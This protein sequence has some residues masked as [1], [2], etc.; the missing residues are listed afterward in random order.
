M[1]DS[2]G[3]ALAA[4]TT[5][6]YTVSGKGDS[7]SSVSLTGSGTTDESGV[8]S[9]KLSDSGYDYT[10]YI[11]EDNQ[12]TITVSYYDSEGNLTMQGSKSITSA[13]YSGEDG[14]SDTL[15]LVN[16]YTITVTESGLG[17]EE[18]GTITYTTDSSS[19]GKAEKTSG[20]SNTV[21]NGW[22]GKIMVAAPSGYR[23]SAIT[24]Q[25]GADSAVDESIGDAE[26][27]HTITVSSGVTAALK[28]AVTYQKTYTVSTS[29]TSS[30]GSVSY[31]YTNSS[32]TAITITDG[33][34]SIVDSG[35][36]IT[37][38]VTPNSGYQIS[39]ITI[40][41]T[42]QEVSDVY[43]YTSEAYTVSTDTAIVVTFVQEYTVSIIYD[44]NG[45][46]ATNPAMTE[47]TNGG[48]VTLKTGSSLKVT[49]TPN[50]GYRVFSVKVQKDGEEAVEKIA[51]T[52]NDTKW[53]ETF[54]VESTYTITV[55]FAEN[56]YGVTVTASGSD[57]SGC[58]ASAGASSV[59]YNGETDITVK[60]ADGYYVKS[61]TVAETADGNDDSGE[62]EAF[63]YDLKNLTYTDGSNEA[64]FTVSGVK[65]D[66]TVTVE[67]A[68]N[69]AVS[70]EINSGEALRTY[71]EGDN[72]ETTVYVYAGTDSAAVTN[73]A[74][75]YGI[76]SINDKDNS[77]SSESIAA[78]ADNKEITSLYFGSTNDTDTWGV[79]ADTVTY[80]AKAS[81]NIRVAFDGADPTAMLSLS[82]SDTSAGYYSGKVTVSVAASDAASD[83]DTDYSGIAKITYYTSE[84][85]SVVTVCSSEDSQNAQGSVDESFAVDVTGLNRDV[86][87]YVTVYD[88]AGNDTTETVV[89]KTYAT[90]IAIT[91]DH[92]YNNDRLD[93]RYFTWRTATIIVTDKDGLFK[94]DKAVITVNGTEQTGIEWTSDTA[95]TS[96]TGTV[97]Y[98]ATVSFT[99]EAE[100]TWSFDYSNEAGADYTL[101]S[102]YTEEDDNVTITDDSN[103]TFA[104][105]V[106][107]TAPTG[108]VLMDYYATST[109]ESASTETFSGL[110][111][112][113]G[114]TFD[115]WIYSLEK[116]YVSASDTL[117]GYNESMTYYYKQELTTAATSD[118]ST[119]YSLDADT[120][121]ALWDNW[122]SGGKTDDTFTTTCYTVSSD[123]N[124]VIYARIVDKA[125]NVSWISSDGSIV[126]QTAPSATL[127]LS[128]TNSGGW[129]NSD[130]EVTIN[131]A[132]PDTYTD[133]N[134]NTTS[135]NVSSGIERIEYKV[136]KVDRKGTKSEVTS[137]GG[138]LYVKDETDASALTTNASTDAVTAWTTGFTI[139][140]RAVS[141]AASVIVE[142]TVY[143]NV[144]NSYVVE[145]DNLEVDATTPTITVTYDN[146]D[147]ENDKYFDAER[148]AT[149]VITERS[150]D[151]AEE[152]AVITITAT[153]AN[154]DAVALA[155]VI[156]IADADGKELDY[157]AVTGEDGIT[158]TITVTGWTVVEAESPDSDTEIITIIYSGDANYTFDISYTGD[159]DNS[160][161]G[162]IYKDANGRI[163]DDAAKVAGA[164]FTVDKNSPSGYVTIDSTVFSTLEDGSYLFMTEP[165]SSL[166]FDYYASAIT[167]AYA[168]ATDETSP[169]T[170]TYYKSNSTT[171]ITAVTDLEK[172]NFVS[173]YEWTGILNQTFVVYAKIEDY[174]GNVTYVSS[175]GAIVDNTAPEITI[176]PSDAND[177][178]W[179]NGDIN[180]TLTATDSDV[181][182][183]DNVDGDGKNTSSGINR[184]VYEVYTADR[185]G[186][187]SRVIAYSVTRE[188]SEPKED[189]SQTIN[190]ETGKVTEWVTGFT[191]STNEVNNAAKVI[192]RATVYDNVGNVSETAEEVLYVDTTA[193]EILVTYDLNE[194]DVMNDT[195]FKAARTATVQIT[196]RSDG[197]NY[198]NA[199][200]TITAEDV[201]E[202]AI[203]I[204]T[205]I[206]TITDADG[207]ELTY[208]V[209][210]ETGVI[211]VDGWTVNKEGN[212]KNP[213]ADTM[214]IKI[215]YTGDANYTFAIAYTDLAGNECASDSESN[216][217]E[218][219]SETVAAEEFTV[220]TDYP[221]GYITI[222]SET[223]TKA[224]LL[225][226]SYWYMPYSSYTYEY[227]IKNVTEASATVT[228]ATSPIAEI[229]YYK[230]NSTTV[231][232]DT[233]VLDGYYDDGLFVSESSWTESA[234]AS[235]LNQTFVVYARI[236]DYAGNVTYVSSDA[237][238]ADDTAPEVTIIP[239]A[240][241]SNGWYDGNIDIILTATDNDTVDAESV[242]GDGENT[243]SGINRIKYSV[244]TLGR[245]ETRTLVDDL[246]GTYK[247]SEPKTTDS[248]T[249]NSSTGLVTSW[250]TGITIDAGLVNDAVAVIVVA[251]V[252]DNAGNSYE[253]E[254]S[255]LL[256]IKDP[257]I[258]VTYDDNSPEN[259]KYFASDRT[260]TV[261]ITDRA[262]GFDYSNAKITVTATDA[263]GNSLDITTDILKIT[264]ASGGELTYNVSGNTIT[265]DGWTV[266]KGS[267]P[268]SDTQTIKIVYTGDANYTF[269]IS[270]TDLAGNSCS[271]ATFANG[272]KAASAFTV[273]Q[274]APTGSITIDSDNTWLSSLLSKIT[275][276]IIS[277]SK[278]TVELAADDVTSPIILEYYVQEQT[279]DTLDGTAMTESKLAALDDSEWTT[280]TNANDASELSKT[281]SYTDEQIVVY[282]RITDYA[283]NVTY[284]GSNGAI[285]DTYSPTITLTP[286]TPDVD[287]ATSGVYGYYNRSNDGTVS[288]AV[289]VSDVDADNNYSALE[290]VTYQVLCNG[291]ETQSGTLLSFT[292]SDP[293]YKQ[294][295]NNSTYSGTIDVSASKNNS[296]DVVVKVTAVDKAGNKTTKSVKLDIDVTAP[297][298]SISYDNN[299]AENS[300]YFDATRTATIVITERT[301]HFDSD[302]V[303]ITITAVDA[304]GNTV[305]GATVSKMLS[306]WKTVEGSD[307]NSA[308]HTAT[309]TYSKDANYTF[310]ISYTDT[311]GNTA[312]SASTGD[313]VAPYKFTVDT[314][315]PTGT[316]TYTSAEGSTNT[317]SS[318]IKKLT[319][320]FYSN[321]KITVS[322]TSDDVTSPIASVKY[323]KTSGT[324]ALT[325]S[326]LD[327]LGSSSWK[328]FSGFS[329]TSDEQF[330]V[331][332]K[333][334]DNAGNYTYIST[335]G[336][337]VDETRP[338]EETLAPE[339]TLTQP[340]N[341][342]YSGDVTVDVTVA[343]PTSGGTYSGLKS[344]TYEVY[345]LGE[346]TQSGTLYTFTNDSPTQSQ[347]QQTI[348]DTVKVLASQNNSND[349]EIVIYAEDNS[350]NTSQASV[351]CMIDTTAP[352]IDVAYD[353]NS[354][355]ATNNDYFKEDR[356]ATITI[357]E[358]NFDPDDVVVT[359]T[360]TDGTIPT[361]SGWTKTAGTGNE[362]NTT[363]TATITYSADGDYTFAIAYT[364]EAGNEAG[365][366][367]Y[368]SGTVAGDEFTID[369]TIPTVSVAYNN[370]DVLN[371]NYYKASRTATI[372]I[373]EHNFDSGRVTI[374]AT[375]EG[376]SMTVSPTWSTSGDVHTA[377]VTFDE[378]A[379]YTFDISYTDMAGNDAADYSIDSFYV[380]L[381]SP[382]I[383]ISGVENESANTGTVMPVITVTDTNY[384]SDGIVI[385]LEG[386]R[387]GEVYEY[388][389]SDTTDGQVFSYENIET[390][391]IYVLTAKATDLAGNE[392]TESITFS[393]NRNGSTYEIS[394][395]VEINNHYLQA[396]DMM[397]LVF[398]E[399]NPNRL[400]DIVITL[401]KNS[402]AYT[403]VEGEDYEVVESIGEGGWYMYTYTIFASVFE[404][405]GIYNIHISSVDEAGNTTQNTLDTKESDI[406]FVIDNTSPTIAVANLIDGQSEN[407]SSYTV[408]FSVSDNLADIT[409][410]MITVT[411][412]GVEVEVREADGETGVYEFDIDEANGRQEVVVTV[413]D[414]AGNVETTTISRVVVTTNAWVRFYTNTPLLVGTIIGII[415]LIGLIIFFII[416]FKRRKKDEEEE[417]AKA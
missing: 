107:K 346:L 175:D 386:Q 11:S 58:T 56:N 53:E 25:S 57:D 5:L 264:D 17:D 349:V 10:K 416:L 79:L 161:D 6:F 323:Y 45:S 122:V 258:D 38:T 277:D 242:E 404:E 121:D 318:L 77:D 133:E 146:Y 197:F 396:T 362:D 109:S 389:P 203:D 183:T 231:I 271:T 61:I 259:G 299:D 94:D 411:V 68:Q 67:Y 12:F 284:I 157:I 300:S 412:N 367:S 310:A 400:T 380:D 139:S 338:V 32:N 149:I 311:A 395:L 8:L 363:W 232:T 321:S 150:D 209:D 62:N 179:Y 137:Q 369:K 115:F 3:E 120:L 225:E 241:N 129:F 9:V 44:G 158:N 66:I 326:D 285:S 361:I 374:T 224:F 226:N 282:I 54:S 351:T 240:A 34:S 358:R 89:I 289:A 116:A 248:Q 178:G 246:S 111:L 72:S 360:N 339:I 1:L 19:T 239:E 381:T 191:I 247:V 229:T 151:F 261:V 212:E 131:A 55:T 82:D 75:S 164:E 207:K 383:E 69:P 70:Y 136:Y 153:D 192:V 249:V 388:T 171:P 319:F 16:I 257:V 280:V 173:E 100:Y 265:V 244:Y 2:T 195:Y 354:P 155:D 27:E 296:C 162:I 186:L 281:L 237:T 14:D 293:T 113:A 15:T 405:D 329:V 165:Y 309:I 286:E 348:S 312:K 317:R 347:L 156:T 117:S 301:S 331:Y 140:A 406:Q 342:I 30:E 99:D 337:I 134:S 29:Y 302:D 98:K 42:E 80:W 401:Y 402:E 221:G 230:S 85:S 193:P 371:G 378:D 408:R 273:D 327:A 142:A 382:G 76:I 189:D 23:I 216:P 93:S 196:D 253:T 220:D 235:I 43:S 398:T 236:V 126:D 222:S 105:T 202:E 143:D 145:K 101:D 270:Y 152:N 233:A 355:D 268:D 407:A 373:T 352:T 200:I 341:D 20:T 147:A 91:M 108:N 21:E 218:Y 81:A 119:L 211:T 215:V 118:D 130:I 114:L 274:T 377:T 298:I 205:D 328:T 336:L 303:N 167:T 263:E 204:T 160:N 228:D 41:G 170:I 106:D 251:V 124:F 276:G 365:E 278:V 51:S 304:D 272:T 403:L 295:K 356:T 4:S 163:V 48:T 190:T 409:L 214:T 413:T 353:N 60:W 26:T 59:V 104:F 291:E 49:A 97:T 385:T 28:I 110:T 333:I 372:T 86:T 37:V 307:E 7:G 279:E 138:T 391:D 297:T 135:E 250:T 22:I 188:A 50:T 322:G 283:G 141:N 305:S 40:G 128:E 73:T 92:G 219:A 245:N 47:S 290:S 390:D 314:T 39:S 169:Y 95:D 74:V 262:D 340:V 201:N 252:Y 33:F 144:G 198:E 376:A 316:I 184:I 112:G 393:V 394:S 206:V 96:T 176:T 234:I 199:E 182:D 223:G 18:S 397:D 46:V 334:T 375:K 154:G 379:L 324:T 71:T 52:A 320:G 325:K 63:S 24:T 213:D 399:T 208:T 227:W 87:V 243:S 306:S 308:T 366:A 174:A 181:V 415:V 343:D 238:V 417:E 294:L 288:V 194:D 392:S 36:A 344:V 13:T 64:S 168:T 210:E 414:S 177:N 260:A 255:L 332:L 83:S 123:D 166:T 287:N 102:S 330:T 335:D 172:L 364:D 357:T 384:N 256:D 148:T 368:A 35:T 90:C 132:D 217:V 84:D 125:G 387:Y 267:D 370:T 315:A 345:N 159:S 187:E 350:G 103:S 313:S 275:F 254:E 127:S 266:N 31:T 65:V 88:F 359:I 185:N 180:I 410:D 78:S 269:A 292:E